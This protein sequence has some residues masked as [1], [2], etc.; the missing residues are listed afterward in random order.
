MEVWLN[1]FSLTWEWA[2]LKTVLQA[3]TRGPQGQSGFTFKP[4]PCYEVHSYIQS[5]SL[6]LSHTLN[7][8]C[9]FM[10]CVPNETDV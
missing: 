9:V 8:V 10:C 1:P 5:Q 3:A 2:G 6:S 7:L 4:L